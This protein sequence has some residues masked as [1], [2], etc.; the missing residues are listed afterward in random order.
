MPFFLEPLAIGLA[1]VWSSRL[2]KNKVDCLF[3]GEISGNTTIIYS[4]EL[5]LFFHAF[6][7]DYEQIGTE[8]TLC[9]AGG[10][11]LNVRSYSRL[12]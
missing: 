1:Y 6:S 8:R 10:L 9:N 2:S 3:F 5:L 11:S 7:Y 4:L 12:T